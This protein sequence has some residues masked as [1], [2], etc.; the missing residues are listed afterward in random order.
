MSLW[1]T[2]ADENWFYSLFAIRT[3]ACFQRRLLWLNQRTSWLWT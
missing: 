3:F 2:T 1:R